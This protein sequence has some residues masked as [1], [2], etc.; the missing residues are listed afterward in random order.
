MQEKVSD[1][2]KRVLQVVVRLLILFLG[3]QL[4]KVVR[5]VTTKESLQLLLSP[6]MYFTGHQN[7]ILRYP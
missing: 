7:L 5:I 2:L 1:S 4:C 3:I 6:L